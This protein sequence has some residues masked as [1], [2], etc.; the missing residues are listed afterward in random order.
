[1]HRF[2]HRAPALAALVAL[3]LATSALPVAAGTTASRL[4]GLGGTLVGLDGRPAVGHHVLLLDA[5]GRTVARAL[6]SAKG[7]YGFEEVVPGTY[8]LGVENP[9]GLRAPVAGAPTT[10][11][12][13]A[14]ERRDVRLYQTDP[15][16][17]PPPASTGQ[18]WSGLSGAGKTW[19]VVGTVAIVA[20]ALASLDEDDAETSAS[21]SLPGD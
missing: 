19:V 10:L 1:M 15:E 20:I 4:G 5:G 8:A 17:V 6:T 7:S 11:R 14:T 13:G 18:W 2:R 16:L 12:A 9:A 21:P 3:L